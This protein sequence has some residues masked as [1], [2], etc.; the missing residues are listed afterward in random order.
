[1]IRVSH[2]PNEVFAHLPPPLYPRP[3]TCPY[4]CSLPHAPAGAA[5]LFSSL[6][7]T[8]QPADAATSGSFTMLMPTLAPRKARPKNQ[9]DKPYH[10]PVKRLQF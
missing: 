2:F 1:M 4:S 6:L 10:S 8:L 3:L 7:E 5:P 9:N